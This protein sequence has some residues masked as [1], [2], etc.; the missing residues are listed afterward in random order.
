MS[1]LL[2][3]SHESEVDLVFSNLKLISVFSC[4]CLRGFLRFFMFLYL[5]S[6]IKHGDSKYY[7]RLQDEK[8]KIPA[9]A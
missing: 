8:N 6:E 1:Q 9:G 7:V 4:Y 2:L 5:F 3:L